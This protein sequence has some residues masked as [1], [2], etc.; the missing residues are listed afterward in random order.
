MIKRSFLVVMLACALAACS[1]ITPLPAP[2][3]LSPASPATVVA[4]APTPNALLPH[5]SSTP[6][7]TAIPT[8]HPAA[9]SATPDPDQAEACTHPPD[10]MTHVQVNG[11]TV[12]G[13]TLW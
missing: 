8:P 4:A 10:D 2:V 7:R 12:N 9:A 1:V 11:Q 6:A 3:T 13:R 5:P